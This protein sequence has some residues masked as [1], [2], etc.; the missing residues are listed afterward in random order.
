MGDLVAFHPKTVGD[1]GIVNR[2]FVEKPTFLNFGT[3]HAELPG[4]DP[5]QSVRQGNSLHDRLKK[6]LG[7]RRGGPAARI[8]PLGQALGLPKCTEQNKAIANEKGQK[9]YPESEG[10][11]RKKTEIGN[12]NVRVKKES[13]GASLKKTATP[14]GIVRGCNARYL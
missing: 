2:A 10:N 1:R 3:T 5:N 13:G 6:P 14:P 12:K 11:Q 7:R 9:P 4:R 8:I